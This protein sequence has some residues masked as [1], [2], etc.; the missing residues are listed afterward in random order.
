MSEAYVKRGIKSENLLLENDGYIGIPVSLTVLFDSELGEVKQGN[1]GTYI[2]IYVKGAAVPRIGTLSDDEII[3]GMLRRGYA[4]VVFDYMGNA[5]A[6]VPALDWSV[7]GLRQRVI[8]GEL[9]SDVP[10]FGADRY[11]ETVVVPEGYDVI[12]DGVFW[13]IDK[14][15][16]AG[17]LEKICEIWNNDFRGV[18]AERLVRWVDAEGNR[19]P[20]QNG[21][22]GTEP[23]WLDGDGNACETGEYVA[24]KH[25]RARDVNDCA[26]PDGS[27]IELD[28]YMNIIYPTCPE[29]PVP[30]AC[31]SGSAE[32]LC[33]GSATADRPHLCGFLVRGY[34]GVMF[35]YGYTPMARDDHYGYFDGFPQKGHITGDN[36]TYAISHYN[37]KRIFTAAM[38]Y[39]RYLAATD[40]RL[41]IDSDNIGV[42]GNSKGAWMTFLGE[43]PTAAMYRSSRMFAC[44]HDETRYE[45]GDTAAYGNVRG[46]EEQP[47]LTLDGKE[48]PGTAQFIYSSTGGTDNFVTEGHTPMYISC[49]RRD[50]SCYS[51]SN[52]FANVCRIYDVPTVLCEIPSA[53]TL[54][55]GEDLVYGNDAYDAFFDFAGYVLKGDAV[56]GM[57]ARVDLNA[58]GPALKLRFT[59]SVDACEM[60]HVTLTSAEGDSICGEW[61]GSFGGVEWT[62]MPAAP[63]SGG[64]YTLFVSEEL[65]GKN[66]KAIAEPYTYTFELKDRRAEPLGAANGELTISGGELPVTKLLFGV[67]NDGV[68]SIGLYTKDGKRLGGVNTSGRGMYAINVTDIAGAL[69]AG[70]CLHVYLRQERE[71]GSVTVYSEPLSGGLGKVAAGKLVRL[72]T[73]NAPDGSAAL[74]VLGFDSVKTFPTEEFYSYQQPTFRCEE[75]V[76]PEPLSVE[77]MGRK[78]R[79]SLKIFDT[80]SR[81]VRILLNNC[82]SRERSI[83]D[84][85]ASTYNVITRAG[86]WVDFDFEYTVYEPMYGEA[87]LVKK[88]LEVRCYADGNKDTP[89]YFKDV[90][91]EEIVTDT[92]L[93]DAYLVREEAL[94]IL[95]DGV[96]P[97]ECKESPWVRTK[98]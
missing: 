45:I 48:I 9:L 28:L 58:A 97:I 75:I 42:F 22:D 33:R 62:F 36:T 40:S 56:K 18:K 5:A 30:V 2:M 1:G 16:A 52:A 8:S 12:M 26:R 6:S 27:P 39:I 76:K 50:S 64:T 73:G 7:Q 29:K 94:D 53:H 19:K 46:G 11:I 25:T 82:T 44:H 86:E 65:R 80:V 67:E 66:G 83:A 71:A 34:C 85:R 4:V 10:G 90:L 59:G 43:K 23:V 14:H 57:S 72:G 60:K 24:V 38:R 92:I 32:G 91:A 21:H 69:N 47:W 15:A 54:A 61:S 55:Y 87:G 51:T 88:A 68:N 70:E 31:L 63:L 13:S 78:Y 3:G 77:D 96:S 93:G 20:V 35:D 84:Y 95:P 74:E 81:Y 37:D 79:I 49:N 41:V 17:T 98:K 89:I